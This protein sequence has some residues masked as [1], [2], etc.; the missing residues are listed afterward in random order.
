L[1]PVSSERFHDWRVV[2]ADRPLQ[3]DQKLRRE[4]RPAFAQDQV[5]GVLNAQARGAAKQVEGIEQFL[6][7]E[8]G[9]V[10]R[11]FLP[12][13]RGFESVRCTLMSSAG[14][15][16]N[17]SQFAQESPDVRLGKWVICKTVPPVQLESAANALILAIFE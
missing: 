16:E 12:G 2:G 9:D 11:M 15:V 1:R 8:E 5:V 3:N 6:N 14:V 7:V 10:P 13:K 17:D 4:A